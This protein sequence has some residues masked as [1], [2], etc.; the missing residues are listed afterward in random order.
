VRRTGIQLTALALA[1]AL[2]G[3]APAKKGKKM[4]AKDYDPARTQATLQTDLGDITLKFYPEKAPHHVHNFIELS[5]AGVY[6]GVLFHRVIPGFMIQT[7]DPLTKDPKTARELMGTGSYTVSGGKK[8][9][10][11]FSFT[12]AMANGKTATVR[13]VKAEF[14]DLSHKRGIVSMARASDPNSAS[15]QFFIVV[16]DSTFLDHQYT[17][18]GEV[19][20]GMEVA[21]KIAAVPRDPRDNPLSPVHIKKVVLTQVPPAQK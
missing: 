17:A 3:A 12:S 7:G 18:F 4:T 1:A 20:S 21:D 2:C 9:E 14:N 19:V 13:N 5:A 8:N 10:E 11:G 16:K 6:D 15:S